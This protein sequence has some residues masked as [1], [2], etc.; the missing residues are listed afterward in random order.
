MAAAAPLSPR[1][2]T[3]VRRHVRAE[4]P[5]LAALL[6]NARKP[7]MLRT[8]DSGP[9]RFAL[10]PRFDA[11][12]KPIV[13]PDLN[14]LARRIQRERGE[15]AIDLIEVGDLQFHGRPDARTGVQV[16]TL[17]DTGGRDR[18]IGYA[19]LDNGGMETLRSALRRNAL[20]MPAEAA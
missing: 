11:T 15:Q 19:W 7:T 9:A 5:R 2:L 20:V 16:F 10:L 18:F 3:G 17:D 13:F 12:V 8:P 4:A 14:S 1:A 6:L